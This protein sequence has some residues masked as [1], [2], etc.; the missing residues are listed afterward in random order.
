[1]AEELALQHAFG[2]CFAVHGEERLA[3]TIAPVVQQPRHQFLAGAALALNE[4]GGAAGGDTAHQRQQRRALRALGDDRLGR[5]ASSHFPPQLAVLALQTSE[6]D[7]AG[8]Q[9]AQL[10]V[11]EG[12]GDVVEGALAHRRHRRRNAAVRGQ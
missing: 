4:H 9:R 2:E 12:L 3:D 5:V 11:V 10:V 8:D 6:L 1:M 7:G